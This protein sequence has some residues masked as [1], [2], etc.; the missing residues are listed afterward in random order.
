ME[1]QVGVSHNIFSMTLSE[2]ERWTKWDIVRML[3]RELKL[4]MEHV[5]EVSK[6]P[7]TL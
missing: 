2:R 4:P 7:P 3:S 5:T 1:W 6:I